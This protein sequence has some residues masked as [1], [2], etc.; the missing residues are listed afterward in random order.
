MQMSVM[1]KRMYF[2]SR[3]IFIWEINFSRTNMR[4][5]WVET[6]GLMRNSKLQVRNVSG[7]LEKRCP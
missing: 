1:M 6:K 3:D 4:S 2:C 7:S 5:E